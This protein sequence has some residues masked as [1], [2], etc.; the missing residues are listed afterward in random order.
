DNKLVSD[1]TIHGKAFKMLYESGIYTEASLN[2]IIGKLLIN[3]KYE[4]VALLD[5]PAGNR[6]RYPVGTVIDLPCNEK[7][8]FFLWALSTFDSDL[9]AHTSM[10]EY[11]LAVQK[12][13]EACNLESEGYPVVLPLV[14]TGLSRTKKDQ[15]DVLTYLVNVFRLNKSE[16][17]SDIHIIIHDDIKNEIAIMNIK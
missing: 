7:E 8:H 1:M 15:Q 11:S 6:K 9:K 10:Q 3:V 17:N 14:G 13:V 12:L 5:K 16:I 2:K 4:D